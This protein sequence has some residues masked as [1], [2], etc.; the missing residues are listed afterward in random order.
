MRV[1]RQY[2]S[3]GAYNLYKSNIRTCVTYYFSNVVENIAVFQSYKSKVKQTR[4]IVLKF[5]SLAQ[6]MMFI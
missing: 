1:W 2:L 3:L 4:N 5:L 6:K